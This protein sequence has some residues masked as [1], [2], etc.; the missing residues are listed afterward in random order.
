MRPKKKS[1]SSK[2]VTLL[3]RIE[4]LLSDVLDELSSIERS[5]QRNVRELLLAAETSVAK[6]K[7]FVTPAL[8]AEAPH[9]TARRPRKSARSRRP[10][11][12]RKAS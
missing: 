7:D 9:K 3:T 12:R 10:A 4:G 6:A 5:V 1:R 2:P 11:R 8:A